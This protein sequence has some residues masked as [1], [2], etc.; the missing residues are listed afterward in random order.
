MESYKNGATNGSKEVNGSKSS[1]SASSASDTGVKLASLAKPKPTPLVVQHTKA[2]RKGVK[3]AFAQYA[4]VVQAT[5]TPLPHQGGV[6]TKTQKWGK[7]T[8]DIKTLRGADFKTLKAVVVGKI[9]GE[10]IK[11]DKTMLMEQVIQLVSNLRSDSKLR[12]ELTN[13]FVTELWETLEHPPMLYVGDKYM[14]RQ[15]DGSN[16][17]SFLSL[18]FFGLVW[19]RV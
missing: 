6:G 9:K 11:D 13:S 15:A 5:V 14:Y 18:F 2:D 17:V 1:T 4:Q 8:D 3:N 7:L 16:N 12:A 19:V 10:K